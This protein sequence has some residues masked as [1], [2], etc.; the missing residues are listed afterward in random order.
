[1]LFY[2]VVFGQGCR[3]AEVFA[4]QFSGAGNECFVNVAAVHLA[5]ELSGFHFFIDVSNLLTEKGGNIDKVFQYFRIFADIDKFL[6]AIFSE[7]FQLA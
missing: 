7:S 1:M 2:V 4:G 5:T 3:L 6:F